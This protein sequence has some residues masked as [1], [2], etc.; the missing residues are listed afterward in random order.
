MVGGKNW[1]LLLVWALGIGPWGSVLKHEIFCWML[2]MSECGL[3]QG[4][5]VKKNTF[6]AES[7]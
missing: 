2:D 5:L 6:A 3:S 4:G 7:F 1:K